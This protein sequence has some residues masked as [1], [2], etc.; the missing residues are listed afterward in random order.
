ML[1]K[2]VLRTKLK[3]AMKAKASSVSILRVILG[4]I[5]LQEVKEAKP[6]DEQRI[7]KIVSKTLEGCRESL[8]HRENV[9][10]REEAAYLEALLPKKLSVAQIR[11]Q[12]YNNVLTEVKWCSSEGQAIGAV[13]KFF[14]RNNIAVDSADISSVVKELRS[15]SG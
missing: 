2:D 8:K 6:L 9:V 11:E 15:C 3:E 4:E 7:A 14:K 13:M 5:D 10:I 1:T 12:I